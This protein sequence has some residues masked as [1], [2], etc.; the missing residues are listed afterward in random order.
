M[1]VLR[2]VVV[3][4]TS[5]DEVMAVSQSPGVVGETM[6]LDLIGGGAWVALRVLVVESRPVIIN[7]SVRHRLRLGL[8]DKVVEQPVPCVS[9]LIAAGP[10]AEAL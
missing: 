2:N 3:N 4:R 9:A 8:L 10:A 1:R 5:P 7:R 6:T